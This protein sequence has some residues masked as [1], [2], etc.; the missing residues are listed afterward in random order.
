M[1][2]RDILRFFVILAVLLVFYI[3]AAWLG[4]RAA[5]PEDYDRA[6][7]VAAI[8]TVLAAVRERTPTTGDN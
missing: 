8:G 2:F 3:I 1:E 5:T 7:I 4:L 6:S